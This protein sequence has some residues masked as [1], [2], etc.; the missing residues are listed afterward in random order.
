MTAIA[1]TVKFAP[2]SA[3]YV[4]DAA[5]TTTMWSVWLCTMRENIAAV[6]ANSLDFAQLDPVRDKPRPSGR[7]RIARTAQPSFGI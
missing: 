4:E 6:G 2:L 5:S 7:G 3:A 1:I